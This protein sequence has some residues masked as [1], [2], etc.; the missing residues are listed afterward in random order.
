MSPAERQLIRAAPRPA[1]G[2]T[3]VAASVRG[4]RLHIRQRVDS[5]SSAPVWLLLHGLA[6]SHR[7]LMP[8]AAALPGSVFVPDLPG[9]GLSDDP[10][11]VLTVEQHAA[12]VADWM[13]ASG[14]RGVNV[15]ANSFGCQVAVEL[16]IRRPEL[17][18][19]LVLVGP[20]ADPAAATAGGLVRRWLRDLFR[21][22]P[23]QIPMILTDFRDAG[24]RRIWRTLGHSV[25]HRMECRIPLVDVPTLVLRGQYDPIAPPAWV[26]EAASLASL[27][28]AADVPGAAH[29]AVTTAGAAVA[30][31]A[32]A[33][34]ALPADEHR[35][36][37]DHDTS[38]AQARRLAERVLQDWNMTDR[39]EDVLLVTTELVQ[40]VS[41]HTADGGE[42]RLRRQ[43]D[44]ILIEV[45]DS[46]PHLPQVKHSAPTVAGGRG[47]LLVASTARRWGSRPVRWA[48]QA[49]KIV[50]AEITRRRPG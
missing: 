1:E 17:V 35:M 42:L 43:D 6:V 9:F 4:L 34:A 45:T 44:A 3:S 50:W 32:Q 49:G 47:L 21:E 19:S 15:L 7:Y 46:D 12:V 39:T 30:G 10:D 28:A 27:G 22:D 33:H 31:F 11:G 23:H 20:T 14:L 2:F 40:N 41:K 13:V 36:P 25:D 16:A 37:L 5:G 18:A 8:T 24:P 48:G 38:P 26:T 29:N